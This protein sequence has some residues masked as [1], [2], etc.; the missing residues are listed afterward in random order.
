MAAAPRVE[1]PETLAQGGSGSTPA[2]E[3][4][5]ADT[6]KLTIS[7]RDVKMW[8]PGVPFT[9]NKA[10]FNT[11]ELTDVFTWFAEKLRL[12]ITDPAV[13]RRTRINVHCGIEP[14]NDFKVSASDS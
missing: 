14:S 8:P 9:R 4:R 6:E 1:G 12:D 13:L 5:V 10:M 11:Q 7:V 2:D 3:E